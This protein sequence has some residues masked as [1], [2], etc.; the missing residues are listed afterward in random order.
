M[1]GVPGFDPNRLFA[2]LQITGLANKDQQLYQLL[3]LMIQSIVGVKSSVSSGSGSIINN[4]NIIQQML[5]G[6]AFDGL[7]GSDGFSL[8]GPKGDTGATGATGPTGPSG[9][10]GSP[11]PPSMSDSDGNSYE[12]AMMF[13]LDINQILD[14]LP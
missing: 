13:G 14:A 1:A 10:N 4:T 9:S 3:N 12:D 5:G 2:Q 7:D 6:P 11:G 8:V